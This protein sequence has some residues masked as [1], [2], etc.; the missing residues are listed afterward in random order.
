M[1]SAPPRPA[2]FAY[3]RGP[4]VRYTDGVP[5]TCEFVV[6]RPVPD[7]QALS[8]RQEAVVEAQRVKQQCSAS[9]LKKL[10]DASGGD[11]RVSCQPVTSESGAA[12]R[13]FST[14]EAL[15]ARGIPGAIPRRL[16]EVSIYSS[17]GDLH[18]N[19]FE[20]SAKAVTAAAARNLSTGVVPERPTMQRQP[21][22]LT[23]LAHA[24][25]VNEYALAPHLQFRSFSEEEMAKVR[26]G[27]P[28]DV[29]S[30]IRA[31]HAYV[32]QDEPLPVSSSH[33]MLRKYS[34]EEMAHGR[35][36]ASQACQSVNMEGAGC[37]RVGTSAHGGPPRPLKGALDNGFAEFISP[38]PITRPGG[39]F[40]SRK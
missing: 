14:K 22:S 16:R 36:A 13:Q 30:S 1:K 23:S 31:A 39:Y 2:F 19:R 33:A 17:T 7:T 34:T 9:T 6:R 21:N 25:H 38:K 27:L 10:L 29:K 40:R 12:F 8:S 24:G 18:Q 28:E 5:N 26:G 35:G 20:T 4:A 3:P 15:E 32:R 37:V 11:T